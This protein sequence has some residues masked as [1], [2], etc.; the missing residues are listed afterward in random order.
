LSGKILSHTYSDVASMPGQAKKIIKNGDILFS[1][2]RPANKRYALVKEQYPED[3]VVSTKLMVLRMKNNDYSNLK[4]FF[5]L[6]LPEVLDDLQKQ[7]DGASGT[8][9]QIT[10]DGN[11]KNLNIL[12]GDPHTEKEWGE[13]L[14]IYYESKWNKENEIEKLTELQSLLLA[15]MGQ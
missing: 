14:T 7:A 3:F 5:Y 13:F 6:T 4:V 11:L 10:F 2:I 15:K 9:P 8:F 1:E 12:I